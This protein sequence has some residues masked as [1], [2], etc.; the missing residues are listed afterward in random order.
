MYFLAAK[1]PCALAVKLP[2]VWIRILINN[3]DCISNDLLIDCEY[4]MSDRK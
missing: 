4:G 2:E 1:Q 3:I